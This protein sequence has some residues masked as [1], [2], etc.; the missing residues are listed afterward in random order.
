LVLELPGAAESLT[1]VPMS[2]PFPV[3][4]LNRLRND[5]SEWR[6]RRA[7]HFIS[8]GREVSVSIEEEGAYSVR[9]ALSPLEY[10]ESDV[11]TFGPG[12]LEQRVGLDRRASPRSSELVVRAVNGDGQAWVGTQLR[13]LAPIGLPFPV[14][15][16]TDKDGMAKVGWASHGELHFELEFGDGRDY[17]LK[18]GFAGEAVLELVFD[19]S[20][21]LR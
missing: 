13:V 16:T 1:A 9:V 7:D 19:D 11:A 20:T 17:V 5:G 8:E 14:V 15:K 18:Q 4:I 6:P 3:Y 2:Y 10:L 12:D 21:L